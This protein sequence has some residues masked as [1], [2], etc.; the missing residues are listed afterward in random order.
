M[1]AVLGQ[2]GDESS[3]TLLENER[4]HVTVVERFQ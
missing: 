4:E 1:R 2:C 3:S